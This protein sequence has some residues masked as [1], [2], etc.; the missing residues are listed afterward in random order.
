LGTLNRKK[1]NDFIEAYNNFYPL[2]Y[3]MVYVKVESVDDAKDIC[4]EVFMRLFENFEDVRDIRKW[5]YG[6]LRNVTLDFFKKK[7]PDYNENDLDELGVA[8]VNGFRDTRLMIQEAI[9]DSG[10]FESEKERVIFDLIATYNFSYAEAGKNAG[11][12]ER[13]VK[14]RYRLIIKRLMRYFKGK[15]IKSLEDLL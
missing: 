4:Q 12:S 10:N 6:T 13:Q 5:L 11:M 1:T 14:Y 8:Y 7:K 2:V 9:E 3:S 15:G